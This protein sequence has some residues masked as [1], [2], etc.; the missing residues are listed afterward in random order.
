VFLPAH[1]EITDTAEI[2][3]LLSNIGAADLVTNNE[4]AL[5]SSFVP[6]LFAPGQGHGSLHGHLAR[7]NRQWKS[8][9]GTAALVIAHFVDG[10]ISPN[11][12]PS[13][14]DDGKVVPTWNYVT[15]NVHG[16]VIVHDDPAWTLGVVRRLTDLHEARHAIGRTEKPWTVD[17]APADYIDVMLRAIVGIEIVIER[18]EAKAKLSQNK[19]DADALGAVTDLEMGGAASAA[20]AAAMRNARAVD[21]DRG[22]KPVSRTR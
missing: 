15:I 7:P 19:T 16:R 20:L 2:A 12:Y 18:V 1:F 3:R 8:A 22:R 14:A 13:K 5:T 11:G 4:D 21:P 17:D 10:Y 6:L 9:N